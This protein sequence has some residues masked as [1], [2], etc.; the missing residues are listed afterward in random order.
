MLR[1]LGQPA[2]EAQA[3][4]LLLA[5][6]ADDD[7]VV[8]GVRKY[9][10]VR[11][12]QVEQDQAERGMRRPDWWRRSGY[13]KQV[14]D[15][16]P[17]QLLQRQEEL[18]ELA[19]WCAGGDEA[20]VWWQAGPRAGKS[21]LMSWFVL[22]PPAGV[23]VVSF[24]VTARYTGQSDSTAFTDELID[25]LAAIIGQQ[26][27]PVTSTRERDRLRR[28]LFEAAAARAVKT[29]H[30]LV[31][32]VDGLDEDCGSHPGSGLPSI[33][34]CLPRHLPDGVRVIVAGRP[35]PPL[36]AD[37]N[38]D[39]GH[40]LHQCRVRLLAA[41]PHAQQV[42]QLAQDEL[43]EVLATDPDRDDGL[44]RQVLG[45]VTAS[46]GGLD[47]RDLHELT[48]RPVFEID[49]LL[50][51]V[52][53]R[54]IAG[55]SDPHAAKRVFLFT[56]E[57]LR[58][59]AIDRLGPHTLAGFVQRLH[60][61]ADCYR[62]QRWPAGTPA[63]LLRGYQ[64]MLE[65]TDDLN[66]LIVLAT[67][68]ARHDRML[69]ATGGDAASL[70]EIAAAQ[71]LNCAQPRPDLAAA[72]RLAWCRDHLA[73]RNARIPARLP[74]VWAALGHPIR[75]EALARSIPAPYR[76][77]QALTG[78]VEAIAAGGEHEWAQ[79]VANDAERVARSIAD[80]HNQAELLIGLAQA[81]A[82]AGEHERARALATDAEHV[83]LS[84]LQPYYIEDPMVGLAL[85]AAAVGEYERAEQYVGYVTEPCQ[86]A[87]ALS[88]LARAAAAAG[89]YERALALATDA[90]RVAR[91][92]TDPYQQAQEMT[93]VVEAV[94][95]A[96][97]HERA[98]A[99][100]T[101]AEQAAR[102]ITEPE[103]QAYAL[104]N[105]AQAVAAAGEHERARALATDAE[106]A[107][108]SIT[109]SDQEPYVLNRLAQAL[110]AAGEHEHAEQIAQ[111]L[112]NPYQQAQAMADLVEAVEAVAAAG[113]YERAR[114]LA[115]DAEQI[116]RSI[117]NPDQQASA[118]NG[119][120]QAFAAAG[121]YKRA[122][123]IARSLIGPFQQAYALTGLARAAAA[124][125]EHESARAL[126]TDAEQIARSITNRFDQPQVLAGLARAA[127]AAGEYERAEEIVRSINPYYFQEALTV[128][129][130]VI[131][132]AGEYGQAE[133]IA[134]SISERGQ[135]ERALTG[136]ARAVAVAGEV[137]RAEEIARSIKDPGQ[138]ARALTELA[139]A[140]GPTVARSLSAAALAAGSWT[141]PLMAVGQLDAKALSDFVDEF[142]S[143]RR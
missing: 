70:A 10:A 96:G 76:Q 37:V 41:S 47:H 95:A 77:A 39:P 45:L 101:D 15:I 21:A 13:V 81:V 117:T 106:R 69:D 40:P 46:G 121:E 120:P 105:L 140:A 58:V 71:T 57:T 22:H 98:R 14:G 9:R 3:R 97:E 100:A 32:L 11:A 44:G 6:G 103:K 82:T 12:G 62:R 23:W 86:Q 63:Y 80:P 48:G 51:G 36:P 20:Y 43:D 102:S 87:F 68:P 104:T 129:V 60:T 83:I 134:R 135:Q 139:Y 17:P 122:E 138:Q 114:A 94:A 127:A 25:Q 35:D 42:M 130:E 113:E 61:W 33:A 85:V 16:A 19:A 73:H 4:N 59:Q 52:F 109:R 111:S 7:Q 34:R 84:T 99:L 27:P 107:A 92:I 50:R 108:R 38:N 49:W 65:A 53:G 133:E 1:G 116:A 75:A 119:L 115:T 24:F 18:A 64:R 54:T 56:H 124:A 142:V 79:T 118:L 125:G 91:S 67:D 136:L 88:G 5:L 126:A 110:A 93:G 28:Q 132:A 72:L 143:R 141:I 137:E 78:L 123:K 131:A 29:G 26:V 89:E 31:L 2:D 74:T 90:E 30:R 8:R 66:R 128:L 112:A 55:R